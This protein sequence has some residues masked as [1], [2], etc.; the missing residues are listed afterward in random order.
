[1]NYFPNIPAIQ[2]EGK[3]SQNPLAFRY[4]DP[5]KIILGKSMQDHLRIAIC[6]WHTFCWAGQDIFGETTFDRPWILENSMQAA[7]ARVSAA[8]EFIE[9]LGVRYFTFHDRDVAPEGKN[10]Q[11]SNSNLQRMLEK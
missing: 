6:Y 7:E 9:K 1:M 5:G 10:L 3:D 2:F 11:E 8:F 4:Y